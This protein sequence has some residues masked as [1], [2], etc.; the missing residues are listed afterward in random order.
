M[1][2]VLLRSCTAVALAVLLLALGGSAAEDPGRALAGPGTVTVRWGPYN[3][4]AGTHEQPAFT[5]NAMDFN[6]DMPCTDCYITGISPQMVDADGGMPFIFMYAMLHHMVL[7]SNAR[8]DLTCTGLMPERVF[9]AGNERTALSL[10]PGYGYYVGPNDSWHVL[11]D[12]MNMMP[13][14]R[15][16]YLD[17]T[18]TYEP[19]SANLKPVRPLWL[20]VNNCGGSEF[21]VDPGYSDRHPSWLST[22]EGDV[23]WMGGHV[24]DHGISVAAEDVEAGQYFCTSVGGYVVGSPEAPGPGAGS[25]GHPVSTAALDPGDPDYLGHIEHMDTC[26]STMRIYTGEHL[27]LHVQ[28]N[29]PE[30]HNDVM[31]IMIAYLHETNEPPAPCTDSDNDGLT[32]CEEAD[33]IGTDPGNSDTDGDHCADGGELRSDP[34]LGGW[35]D[36]TDPYDFG[37]VDGNGRIQLLGD[38]LPVILAYGQG[39]NDPTPGPNYSTAKDRGAQI[40]AYSWDRAGPDGKIGLLN[41]ILPVILQYGH[42]CT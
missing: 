29:P 39:P 2:T 32:D 8:T 20:D 3:V 5:N 41:D 23:V 16:V 12:I 31:G 19:A 14:V 36:P 25:E 38:I 27:R 15:S 9:A 1:P 33:R 34:M 30:A 18:F 42:D 21:A 22:L 7:L 13:G 4:P 17:F 10:P 24:H 6:V 40:G 26:S 35:R 37:D 28:Y 11:Y